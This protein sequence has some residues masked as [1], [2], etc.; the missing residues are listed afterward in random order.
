MTQPK[1][2][3]FIDPAQPRRVKQKDIKVYQNLLQSPHRV[4]HGLGKVFRKKVRYM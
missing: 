4:K 2:F 1:V 3:I